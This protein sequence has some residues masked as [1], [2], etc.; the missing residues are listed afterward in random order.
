MYYKIVKGD[1]VMIEHAVLYKN[2]FLKAKGLMFSKPLKKGH[3]LIMESLVESIVGNAIHMFF[4]FFPIDVVW[5]DAN[6]NV[7]DKVFMVKPF[8]CYLKPKKP[9]K[10]TIELPVGVSKKVKIGDKLD[11]VVSG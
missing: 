9:A 10:Y 7:V 6:R 5:L 4:V 1:T 11:F 3:A 8:T 2:P